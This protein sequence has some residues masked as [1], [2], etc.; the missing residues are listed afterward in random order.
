[1][2]EKKER[3]EHFAALCRRKGL[4]VTPQRCSVYL[5]LAES[6]GHPTADTIYRQVRLDFPSISPDTVNRTLNMLCDIEAAMV[7]DSTGGARRYDADV[8]EHRHFKCRTCGRIV[9]IEAG[10]FEEIELPE[11]LKDFTVLR[12]AVNFE[13]ICDKCKNYN[14]L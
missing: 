6:A 7:V 4:K 14:N 3:L 2:M 1:M 10:P 5:A 8:S 9:D 13:G 12:I 11:I